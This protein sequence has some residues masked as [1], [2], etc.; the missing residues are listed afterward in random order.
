MKNNG[1]RTM[2]RDGQTIWLEKDIKARLDSYKLIPNEPYYALIVRM[3]N[4][5]DSCKCQNTVKERDY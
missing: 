2:P 3:M 4:K 1:E 5:L